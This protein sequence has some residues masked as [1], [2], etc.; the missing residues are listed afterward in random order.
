MLRFTLNIAGQ[1]SPSKAH[2]R[3]C[4]TGFI[5]RTNNAI[6][7]IINYIVDNTK[8]WL[9][10]ILYRFCKITIIVYGPCILLVVISNCD[11]Y[12]TNSLFGRTCFVKIIIIIYNHRCTAHVSFWS[13]SPGSLFGWIG[14]QQVTVFL[15]VRFSSL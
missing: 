2:G 11:L 12:D 7:I 15:L 4:H 10:W 9:Y 3:F 8:S 14:K 1:L 5:L 13:S 6:N